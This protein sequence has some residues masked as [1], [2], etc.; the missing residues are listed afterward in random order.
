VPYHVVWVYNEQPGAELL[1][2]ILANPRVLSVETW[3]NDTL[4][5]TMQAG[6]VDSPR[7]IGWEA[8]GR[9]LVLIQGAFTLRLTDQDL[10][11]AL[12][13]LNLSPS[14]AESL[15]AEAPPR[16]QAPG[17]PQPSIVRNHQDRDADVPYWASRDAY[18]GAVAR[19]RD[20]INGSIPAETP[21][22]IIEGGPILSRIIVPRQLGATVVY[23]RSN[24]I[25]PDPLPRPWTANLI[26]HATDVPLWYET[27]STLDD[28]P[29]AVLQ[30]FVVTVYNVSHEAG[31]GSPLAYVSS[32]NGF[33]Y[34][35]L[36]RIATTSRVYEVAHL[37]SNRG[38]SNVSY[39][40]NPSLE[41]EPEGTLPN[42]T[43]ISSF[44]G[45]TD[46]TTYVLLRNPIF[47]HVYVITSEV[48]RGEPP[49]PPQGP[50]ASPEPRQ[51]SRYELLSE[52]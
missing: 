35:P 45:V 8:S 25:E 5:V 16:P 4:N 49:A 26:D 31:D 3:G 40:N 34:V 29:D 19:G 11:Q 52:D 39:W 44:V 51:H 18:D 27:P 24:N 1:G 46:S 48:I 23:V 37:Q 12:Q 32:P 28:P 43:T 33:G 47:A 30:G 17:P 6:Y 41:G 38:Y 9:Y 21:I 13:V 50:S 7:Q 15:A 2:L 14:E 22:E 36:V 20:G 10:V 42:G